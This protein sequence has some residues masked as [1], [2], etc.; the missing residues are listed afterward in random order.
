[1][2]KCEE[3]DL[4]IPLRALRSMNRR[5]LATFGGPFLAGPDREHGPLEHGQIGLPATSTIN[6]PLYKPLFHLARS[7]GLSNGLQDTDPSKMATAHP[8]LDQSGEFIPLCIATTIDTYLQLIIL[9]AKLA[10]IL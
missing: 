5:L 2:D 6:H 1:M 7:N 8:S 4:V 10:S 9:G 3:D